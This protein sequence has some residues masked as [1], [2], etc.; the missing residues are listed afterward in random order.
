[1]IRGASTFLV[2]AAFV[3]FAAFGVRAQ[4]PVACTPGASPQ[5]SSGWCDFAT[6]V[7]FK[8]GEHLRLAVGGSATK[9]VVRLLP[10]GGNTDAPIGVIPTPF[11]IPLNRFVEVVVPYDALTIT[12]IS[13]HGGPNP[14]NQYPL[15]AGNGTATIT[16][17]ERLQAAPAQGK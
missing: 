16:G 5:W 4:T 15:G 11:A 9:I 7:T 14:W 3:L 6:P 17:V 13:V 12:Q 1:M 8:K 2:A 10:K